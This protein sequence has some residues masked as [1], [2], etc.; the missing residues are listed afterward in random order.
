MEL[1][2]LFSGGKMQLWIERRTLLPN[3][4]Y[5]L[6]RIA[7]FGKIGHCSGRLHFNPLIF[8]RMHGKGDGK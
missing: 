3:G 8:G 5:N 4:R 1:K 7:G 6:I 2:Y